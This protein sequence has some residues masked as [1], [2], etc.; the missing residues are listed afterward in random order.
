MIQLAKKLKSILEKAGKLKPEDGEAMLAEAQKERRPLSE[1]LVKK[2]VVTEGE[3][4]AHL[5][6]AANLPAIDLGRLKVNKEV[7]DAVPMDVAKDYKIFPI[8]RIGTI[9]TIAVANPFDV[10]KLDDIRIITGCQL[11]PVI[12]TEEAIEKILGQAYRSDEETVGDIL[13]SFEDADLELKETESEDEG[14]DLSAISDE[15]SPVV[16]MVNKI[17][18]EAVASGASDIHI[19]PFERDLAVRFRVD[20]LLYEII[21]PPKRFQQSITSRIKIMGGLNIAEKRLPQDGRIR[22]KIAGKDIDIRRASSCVS[23]TRRPCSSTSSS[24]ASRVIS[25]PRSSTSSTR[26]TGSSS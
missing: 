2:G 4:L 10:V 18:A 21:K 11:R 1:L 20:G 13:G 17:I 25:R 23:S 24:S 16:K 6:R 8:D 7:L 9:L 15:A 19:E 22:I 5:S 26:V 14:M 12:S 3:I